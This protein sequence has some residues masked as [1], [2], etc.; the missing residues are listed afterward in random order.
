MSIAAAEVIIVEVTSIPVALSLLIA[1]VPV[2]VVGATVLVLF[3][4]RGGFPVPGRPFE[5]GFLQVRGS[6][7]VLH[8]PTVPTRV[9]YE[10][11]LIVI[12]PPPGPFVYKATSVFWW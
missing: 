6:F 9:R 7:T 4:A 8:E 11:L 10:P 12:V 1:L 5:S 2:L 3:P